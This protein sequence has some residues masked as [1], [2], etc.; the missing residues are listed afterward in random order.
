MTEPH[1]SDR[2]HALL[3]ASGASRWLNCPPS[4]RLEELF[5]DE[6]SSFAEEGTLAHELC[7]ISLRLALN[8]TT[9]KEF[10]KA[11]KKLSKSELFNGEMVEHAD[12]YVNYVIEEFKGVQKTTPDA[13]LLIEEKIDLRGLI[14]DGF[15]TGDACIIADNVLHIIDLKYGKGVKVNAV[16]NSQLKLYGWGALNTYGLVY[17]IRAVHLHIVQPRL[18][19]IDSWP[20]S[21]G[22]LIGWA[23]EKVRPAA[24][25]AYKGEGEMQAGDWCRWCKAK[26]RCKCLSDASLSAAKKDFEDVRLLNDD[27]LISIYNQLDRITGWIQAVEGYVLSEAIAGK[28]W[29][30]LK[31]VEGRSVRT[32][33]NPEEATN[34]LL[35][36]GFA[37]DEVIN[38]KIKGIGEIEKL[39]GKKV[40][41]DLLGSYVVKPQGKPTLAPID[42]K[43][44]KWVENQVQQAQ[45]D[46]LEN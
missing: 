8:L 3:S 41:P 46:F 1:H 36:K 37:Q 35:S 20:I 21:A 4:P 27:E 30:G 43:R 10:N 25:L 16:N 38:S 40:F 7:E 29:P 19:H 17:D 15:G 34:L 22:D 12:T 33:S 24:E 6:T 11:L 26:A 2:A 9:K 45:S 32:W 23:E 28:E 31:L 14:Q 13:L 18:D 42:D 5:P 44:P 39:V